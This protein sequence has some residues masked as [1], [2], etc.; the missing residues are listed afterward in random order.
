MKSGK[1]SLTF[2]FPL[3][4]IGEFWPLRRDCARLRDRDLDRRISWT[5]SK[6]RPP[7]VISWERGEIFFAIKKAFNTG[8]QVIDPADHENDV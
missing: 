3:R 5:V 4:Q 8:S 6:W 2:P 7:R 1:M